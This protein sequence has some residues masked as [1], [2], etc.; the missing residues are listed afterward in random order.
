MCQAWEEMFPQW[1]PY[2]FKDNYQ[3]PVNDIADAFWLCEVLRCHI[4]YDRGY[5][6]D[7]T[8]KGLLEFST[9]S[10]YGSL[11]ETRME[12]RDV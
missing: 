1:F 8:T 5:E 6:L 11:V 7:S 9:S 3:S 12:I 10:R 2:E 4:K